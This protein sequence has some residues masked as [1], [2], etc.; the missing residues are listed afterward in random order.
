MGVLDARMG[1]ESRKKMK[2]ILTFKQDLTILA[3]STD[4][5]LNLRYPHAIRFSAP[6]ASTQGDSSAINDNTSQ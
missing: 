5:Y 3:C 2:Y 4:A 1:T 6:E